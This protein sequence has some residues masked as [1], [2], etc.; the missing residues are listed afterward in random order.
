MTSLTLSVDFPASMTVDLGF[1]VFPT[2]G[3][4]FPDL[5]ADTPDGWVSVDTV[6]WNMAL[7]DAVAWT[8]EL[9]DAMT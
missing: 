9:L 2:V 4:S 5:G 6:A 1:S 8:M 7:S 3:L